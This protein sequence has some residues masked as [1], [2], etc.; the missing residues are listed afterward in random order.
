M[1]TTMMETLRQRVRNIGMPFDYLDISEGLNLNG[2]HAYLNI[3]QRSNEIVVVGAKKTKNG[4]RK[5]YQAV[6]DGNLQSPWAKVYPEYFNDP[7]L[8][9]KTRKHKYEGD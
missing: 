1:N 9:G 8:P 7:K 5:L 4:S 3:M 2:V 6:I